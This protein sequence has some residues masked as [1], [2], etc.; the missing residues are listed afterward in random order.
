M[1]NQNEIYPG[2]DNQQSGMDS[3]ESSNQNFYGGSSSQG[4]Y[5][6]LNQNSYGG[7]QPY[8]NQG[9]YPNQNPYGGNQPYNNQ[10][11]YPNQN[12]YGGN[13]PYN[14]PGGYPNQ[15]PYG[16]YQANMGQQPYVNQ[17]GYQQYDPN[18][19]PQG[20]YQ[21][22][23]NGYMMMDPS[24]NNNPYYSSVT[25]KKS[26]VAAGLLGIFLG[27]LGIHKFYLGYTAPGVIMLLC[28]I[29]SCGLLGAVMVIIG[30]IEGIKYLCMSDEEFNYT[31]VDN[32]KGWF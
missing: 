14:N 30:L 13:Q 5:P 4:S 3:F 9:G 28:T 24:M 18:Q 31:Y 27:Y 2:G 15:N 21:T 12:P 11:G 1:D 6:N 17:P 26:K 16:G 22:Y 10:G 7:N 25:P 23:E 32:T 29:L 19:N 8:N 20:G